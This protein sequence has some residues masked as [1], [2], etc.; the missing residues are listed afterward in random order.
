VSVEG[1]RENHPGRKT[2]IEL[3]QRLCEFPVALWA[4]GADEGYDLMNDHAAV[5][6]PQ[7]GIADRIGN[8][9]AEGS[10]VISP[11]LRER[12]RDF[13]DIESTADLLTNGHGCRN[14]KRFV[15]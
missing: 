8:Q 5:V 2:R 11:R 13:G 4:R 1:W 12:Q 14:P 6:I 10:E 9:D 7:K 15:R 3:D